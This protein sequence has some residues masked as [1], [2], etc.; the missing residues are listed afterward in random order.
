[1][2]KSRFELKIFRSD[3]MLNHHLSQKLKLIGRGKF[4]HLI[5][6]LTYTLYIHSGVSRYISKSCIFLDFVTSITESCVSWLIINNQW[7]GCEIIQFQF[8]KF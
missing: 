3:T 8:S 7:S 4:N 5:N 6:T 1:M 2:T